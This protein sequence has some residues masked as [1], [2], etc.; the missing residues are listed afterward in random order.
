MFKDTSKNTKIKIPQESYKNSDGLNQKNNQ[1][2][3]F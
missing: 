3:Y 1:E 2:K